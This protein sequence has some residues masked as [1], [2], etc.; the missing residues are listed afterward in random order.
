[1]EKKSC[2]KKGCQSLALRPAP[3]RL[4]QAKPGLVQIEI[5]H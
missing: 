3:S 2:N 4:A 1:M 5:C